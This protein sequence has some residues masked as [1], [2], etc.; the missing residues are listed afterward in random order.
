[1]KNNI[2]YYCHYANSHNH[3]KFKLLRLK[4]GWAG[5]G[6]FWALNN[7]IAGSD[8]CILN[9]NKKYVIASV[10]SDLGM[11]IEEFQEFISYLSKEC[12][13]LIDIDGN[14][15]TEN[16][17]ETFKEVMKQR[18]RNKENREKAI[19]SK[20]ELKLIRPT[21]FI[22]T[23]KPVPNTFFLTKKER[24]KEIKEILRMWIS[25]KLIT[26]IIP[27]WIRLVFHTTRF[28]IKIIQVSQFFRIFI[29]KFIY[30]IFI[31]ILWIISFI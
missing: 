15:S 23:K 30:T 29:T 12:E 18:V 4:Y 13:L 31:K 25:H 6:R 28:F 14:V 20:N 3:P 24:E 27:N 22:V 1:M 19:L 21:W 5:E 2:E 9:L 26:C 10:S 11:S 16:V 17:R 7:I 8:N